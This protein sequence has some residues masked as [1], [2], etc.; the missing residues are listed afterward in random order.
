MVGAV[1]VANGESVGE[2]FH[3]RAGEAHAE[4]NALQA[5]GDRARG[6]TMYVSLEPCNHFGR[7]PPCSHSVAGS[8]IAR[9]V[10]GTLDP[11]PKTNHGGIAYLR[12]RGIDVE[13]ADDAEARAII[14]PFAHAI[15]SERP[16]V[17]LKM[18]ASLDGYVTSRHGE[19]QWLTGEEARAFVR[20]LR[21]EH[22]A[23]LVGAGTIRVDDS[24]LTVRPPHRR[25]RNYVRVIACGTAPI[26]SKRAVFEP[27]DNYEKTIV[28]AP[29]GAM[30]KFQSLAGIADVHSV[31]SEESEKLDLAEAMRDLRAAGIASMLCEGGPILAGNLLAAGLVD[32]IHW[33]IAPRLLRS[34]TAVPALA[35]G[36][37]AGAVRGV[38][39]DRV[40]RLGPDT[41]VSGIIERNV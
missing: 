40:E 30:T 3:H 19:A 16:F 21:I 27:K 8:G 37:V 23:V 1:V 5:A 22:D 6:A 33:L 31:G 24:Q 29:A 14:E 18:A 41:L 11:N 20:Q 9:V 39:I 15:R 34:E 12:E 2:G 4:V 28:L 7:T 32:R 35:S 17:T 13:I 26:D 36:D 10:V 38:R 25:L